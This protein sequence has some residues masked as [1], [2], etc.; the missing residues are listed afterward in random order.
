MKMRKLSTASAS[1]MARAV[2]SAAGMP[3]CRPRMRRTIFSCSGWTPTAITRPRSSG[4]QRGSS[5]F[6]KP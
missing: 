3:A 5:V 2:S 4:T 1:A 6:Q